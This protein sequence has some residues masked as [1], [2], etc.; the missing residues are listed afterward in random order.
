M[1]IKVIILKSELDRDHLLW[2][3]ACKNNERIES[4]RV[5]DMTKNNWL[6]NIRSEK[7]DLILCRPPGITTFFKSLYDERM[8]ILQDVCGYNIYPSLH[9]IYIYENKKLLKDWM[10]A[11]NIPHPKTFV[12]FF[13]EDALNYAEDEKNYP[14]VAKTNIGASGNGVVIL[15]T[16]DEA[17]QY[18]KNA[19]GSGIKSKSGP[20]WLKGNIFKK[21]KKIF[22][23]PAFIG[24]RMKEY[25]M[26]KSE[27]QKNFVFFQEFIPHEF[28]WRCVMIGE[29]YFAHKKLA[30]NNMS[31]GTLL[32][33]YNDVP[34]K[35]LDFLREFRQK[36]GVSSVAVDLFESEGKYLVNEVQ[37]FFGQ[38]DPYQMLVNDKP[39]R[40]IF[41]N[42]RWVFE[43]GMFN[44]NQCYDLRL[45]H[46]LSHLSNY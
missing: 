12:S 13:Q 1:K 41:Q 6:E 44:T 37:C 23:N 17:S 16:K 19:F 22:N 28:E 43:E 42:D 2:I 25:G 26:S 32:K 7:F 3:E 4:Y 10:I 5:V 27:T 34:E 18:I 11:R 40:Y 29:S 30:I 21:A 39:G 36:T 33:G 46:A 38:S 20:K 9:E 45:Q 8:M 24:Q 15:K 14:I 31:S 35:L